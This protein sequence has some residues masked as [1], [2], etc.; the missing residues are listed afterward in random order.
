MGDTNRPYFK[1]GKFAGTLSEN[2]DTFL[3]NYH[4]A[5]LKNGWSENGKAQYIPIFLKENS[6]NI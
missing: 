2:I 1:P 5:A 3:K 6:K 4:W